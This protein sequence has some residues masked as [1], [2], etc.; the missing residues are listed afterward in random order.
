MCVLNSPPETLTFISPPLHGGGLRS[1]FDPFIRPLMAPKAFTLN[2]STSRL[3]LVARATWTCHN[4]FFVTKARTG[5][6]LFLSIALLGVLDVAPI[7]TLK[8]FEMLHPRSLNYDDL[9]SWYPLYVPFPK[10]AFIYDGLT[11]TQRV[12]RGCL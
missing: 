8:K 1:V 6:P 11:S 2:R 7:N 4:G 9:Y 12:Q 3:L 10:D 5:C